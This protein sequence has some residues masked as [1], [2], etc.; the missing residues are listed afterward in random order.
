VD[1]SPL[2]GP[3]G[4]IYFGSDEGKIYGVQGSSGPA[5]SAWPMFGQNPRRTSN[6]AHSPANFI[7]SYTLVS[8]VGDSD[9]ALFSIDGSNLKAN[10]SFDYETRSNY[11]VRV[12]SMSYYGEVIEQVL[13]IDVTDTIEA[14]APKAIA[15]DNYL[16]A[17]DVPGGTLVGILSATDQDTDESHTF[18]LVEETD[19]GTNDNAL[20]QI[21]AHGNGQALFTAENAAL[22]FETKPKPTHPHQSH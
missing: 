7:P 2:L 17:E 11:S 1:G 21:K 12:Q 4:V 8:G 5:D 18:E 14:H 6:A 10:Q 22:D 9:N 20:F 19:G 3:D 15:L 16:I 13:S